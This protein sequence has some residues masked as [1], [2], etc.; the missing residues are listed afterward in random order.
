[1]VVQLFRI[2][3]I[4]RIFKLARH[5]Y[6]LQSMVMTFKN[7]YKELGMLILFVS[8]N[9]LIFSSFSY[10]AESSEENSKFISMPEAA[11]WSLITMTAV[12]YGDISPVTGMGKLIGIFVSFAINL[13]YLF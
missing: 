4:L 10:L 5:S 9:V 12:G 13:Q 8:F 6:G 3:R 2:M 11:W 1:M 7:S